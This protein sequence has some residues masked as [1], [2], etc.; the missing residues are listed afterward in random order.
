[1]IPFGR[2]RDQLDLSILQL[3]QFNSGAA[4]E[5][6]ADDRLQLFSTHA[7]SLGFCDF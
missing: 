2:H 3:T 1:M 5:N 6:K 4:L 7:E